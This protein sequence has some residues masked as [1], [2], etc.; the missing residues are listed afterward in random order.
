M[1][2]PVITV[3]LR[4][5]AIATSILISMASISAVVAGNPA[6]EQVSATSSANFSAVAAALPWKK[7]PS[8][9]AHSN[10]NWKLIFG[11]RFAAP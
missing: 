5:A 1:F 8:P 7:K 10:T 6:V 11:T 2:R 4:L 9:A 3:A